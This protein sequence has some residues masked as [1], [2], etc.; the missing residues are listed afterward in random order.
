MEKTVAFLRTGVFNVDLFGIERNGDKIAAP[1]G[2]VPFEVAAGDDLVVSVVVQNKGI[3]HNHA[4]S[5]THLDVY[6]RQK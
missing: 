1:L 2:N 6:K 5:Y 4:V 3:A